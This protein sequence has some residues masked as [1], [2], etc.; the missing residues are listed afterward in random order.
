MRQMSVSAIT[1]KGDVLRKGIMMSSLVAEPPP[2][3]SIAPG[4]SISGD[5]PLSDIYSFDGIPRT[6]DVLVIW[7]H[8]LDGSVRS[9]VVLL[10]SQDF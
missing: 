5:L 2:M 7:A 9:G 8:P 4:M 6:E 10:P 1:V 3:V